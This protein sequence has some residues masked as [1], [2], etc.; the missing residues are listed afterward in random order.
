MLVKLISHFLC[1]MNINIIGFCFVSHGKESS[2]SQ[3]SLL[4]L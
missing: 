2:R 3:D 4:R 1:R